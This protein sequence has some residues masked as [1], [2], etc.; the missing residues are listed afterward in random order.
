MGNNSPMPFEEALD[1]VKTFGKT[2]GRLVTLMDPLAISIEKFYRE[3]Y[4]DKDNHNKR[5][6][7]MLAVTEFVIRE[8]TISEQGELQGKYGHKTPDEYDPVK[9]KII[10]P[11]DLGGRIH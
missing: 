1:F 11:I 2:I 10:V 4:A 5:L 3:L 7:F 8:V 9:Q 6:S